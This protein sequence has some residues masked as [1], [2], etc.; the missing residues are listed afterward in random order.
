MKHTAKSSKGVSSQYVGNRA[1]FA[2]VV[3]LAANQKAEL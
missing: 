2:I 1:F 3:S